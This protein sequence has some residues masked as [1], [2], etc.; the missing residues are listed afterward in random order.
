ML[1]RTPELATQYYEF[2]MT[3]P[4][5]NNIKVRQAF[6]YAINREKI[7]ETILNGEAYGPGIYGICP[8][9]L[10]GYDVTKIKGYNFDPAKAKKLLAEAGYPEGKNFPTITIE[11]NSGGSKNSKVVEEI[12]N[13]LESTLKIN[14]LY[15]VV[16]FGQKLEDSRFARGAD[17]FR[18]SWIADYPSPENF[19]F[20]LYG[21]IVP[22]SISKPS[23]PNVPRY[24]NAEYDKYFE[25][26]K[27]SLNKEESY[28]YFLKAEQIMMDESPVIILWH[29][30][31]LKLAQSY[32][33]NFHF[34][35]MNYRNF[36]EVYLKKD[37]K[38]P[39]K[40]EEGK[41]N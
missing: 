34:N 38:D 23:F 5:F 40:K 29:D 14:V 17:I 25:A 1:D 22:D 36:S 30:E 41:G 19:L 27:A 26:G 37:A 39:E 18:T 6:N 15:N 32:V 8:Q 21:K 4:P 28:S 33:K 24:K 20:V 9:S 16:P 11:V 10:I 35:P 13:Q 3:K 31:N 2:N 12:K 7:I